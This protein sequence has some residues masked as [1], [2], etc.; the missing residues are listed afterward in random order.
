MFRINN[1]GGNNAVLVSRKEHGKYDKN[2]MWLTDTEEILNF[3]VWQALLYSEQ[4]SLL[5]LW[6]QT[7]SL[8]V[9]KQWNHWNRTHSY[10]LKTQY[11][12]IWQNT[13]II[14]KTQTMGKTAMK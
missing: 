6:W 12:W 3:K 9:H 13:G 2:K 11:K 5:F 7:T 10:N 1:G 14:H 4:K 8:A